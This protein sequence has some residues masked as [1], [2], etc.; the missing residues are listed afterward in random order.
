MDCNKDEAVRAKEI[1][2]RKVTERDYA[3]AMKFA[4]KAQSL[5]PGL[6]GIS[7]LLTIIDVYVSAE[8]RINGEA[9][10]YA[11]LGTNPRVDD[12]TVRKQYRKLALALHPDKNKATGADGAFK[13]VSEAW[14]FL[15]D[16]SKRVAYNEKLYSRVRSKPQSKINVPF[17]STSANGFHTSTSNTSSNARTQNNAT[18]VGPTSAPTSNQKPGTFWT[19]CN[20]CKTQYEYLR[21]YLNHNLL[22]PNCREPFLAIERPPPP[23]AFKSS[24]LSSGQQHQNSRH[25]N[26]SSNNTG[27]FTGPSSSNN[28]NRQRGSF[29]RVADGNSK[30]ASTS[31]ATQ[32]V[33]EQLKRESNEAWAAISKKRRMND[34]CMNGYVGNMAN[35]MAMGK[36]VGLGNVY[37]SRRGSSEVERTYGFSGTNNKYNRE[38]E[39][40]LLETRNMLVNKAQGDIR[41][42]LQEWSSVNA[43]SA[44]KEEKG[45]EQENRKQKSVANGE[46]D[47][48]INGSNKK[49]QNKESLPSSSG[50]DSD[51][52][53]PAL[54]IN[55]PDS[56]FHNFDLDRNENSFGD[57][58][59]WA[60]YDD[61]DG[62]PRFYAR[63][64]KVISLKPFRMRISWLNSRSNSELGPMSWIDSGF[65]KTC[66]DFRSGKHEIS[67]TLNSF[68]HNIKWTKGTRGIIRIF[69]SKGDVW[70]LYSNWSP[71]WN[72]ET[73]DEVIHKYDMVEVLDDYNEEQGVSVRPLVK[74]AT[75]KSV[76]QKNMD[77]KSVWRI[78]KEEM[79]RFSHQVPGHLLT[80]QEAQNAPTGSWE[81]DPAAIPVELLQ[82]STD[83]NDSPLV[84]NDGEVEEET[85]QRDPKAEVDDKR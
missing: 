69:P 36:V 79:F 6:E 59:V 23:N 81:L 21:I 2:E 7:Q 78:P 46:M 60:A 76:Y 11:I 45:K 13:L 49:Y 40:S 68:S 38:R 14:S 55:V 47:D 17:S 10:W 70:A 48:T 84:E 66:G 4:S 53:T 71:D 35:Q 33:H 15:S 77:P 65:A 56:D 41:K 80:G 34:Y 85:L 3:G 62:M 8:K 50:D 73:P 22:C 27:A 25:H 39:L 12:E 52:D 32:Q 5:Y 9:D 30:V 26:A 44:N 28:T 31:T 20:K 72:E 37:E 58:Q 83:G 61:D 24:N 1:A 43:K 82:V 54:S 75:F 29:S 67:E 63:I 57:D 74:L 51:K 19:I 42:K 18:R 16:K 64:H